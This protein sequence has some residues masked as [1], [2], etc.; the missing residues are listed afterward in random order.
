MSKVSYQRLLLLSAASIFLFLMFG[1]TQAG[2][3]LIRQLEARGLKTKAVEKR[4]M[5]FHDFV[6]ETRFKDCYKREVAQLIAGE[7]RE[8]RRTEPIL[9][10]DCE[11]FMYRIVMKP[12]AM[13]PS[14]GSPEDDGYEGF[15]EKYRSDNLHPVDREGGCDKDS[16][17]RGRC[18]GIFTTGATRRECYAYSVSAVS[19]MQDVFDKLN[20][21]TASN[22]NALR[23]TTKLRY[24]TV[25]LNI[26]ISETLGSLDSWSAD[27]YKIAWK[28][29][30]ESPTVVDVFF[31]AELHVN[32]NNRLALEHFFTI[33]S[34]SDVI[35]KLNTSLT[36]SA[37]GDNIIDTMLERKNT[38]GL[39]WIHDMLIAI[40]GGYITDT[41]E[42][43]NP[44]NVFTAYCGITFHT[45][46]EE[47][48]FQ[49]GFFKDLLD[50]ILQ[51]N[52]PGSLATDH[53][54]QADTIAQDLNPNQW[55]DSDTETDETD[56][57]N[58]TVC[59]LL[60]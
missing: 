59:E 29:L 28:W 56:N 41:D 9:Q 18:Q 34:S 17:C 46:N 58:A 54:W 24:L 37:D 13:F 45:R 44:L 30:A 25:L 6:N 3:N 39:L 33:S 42:L 7:C 27:Q 19:Q 48:Y 22:L 31:N 51:N 10:K 49:Y 47:K 1:C 55:W 2:L 43:V 26:S 32:N 60:L 16:A 20:N 14:F 15:L 38:S 12:D 11:D 53:W 21:P 57:A 36:S 4:A 5:C 35:T 8:I 40:N 50:I 23:S 52:Q